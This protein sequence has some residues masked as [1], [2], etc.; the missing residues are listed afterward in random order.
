MKIQTPFSDKVFS[1]RAVYILLPMMI[2]GGAMRFYK[3]DYAGL[4]LDE[5]FSMQE[6]D[7]S[8]LLATVYGLIQKDQPPA[9]FF[10]LHEYLKWTGYSDF[11]GRSLSCILGVF[12]ILAMFFL[13]KE[14]KDERLG[15]FAAF[16]TTINYFHVGISVE[17]RFYPLLFLLSALSYLYFLR[18]I[19]YG[20]DD[21]FVAYAITTGLA[22][23]TH[24][25]GLVLFASQAVIFIIVLIFFKRN[26][27]LV[28]Y[29][30]LAGTA[31]AL[32]VL[33]WLPIMLE[34][35]KIKSFHYP[36]LT[37]P[38]VLKSFWWFVYDPAAFLIYAGLTIKMIHIIYTKIRTRTLA[39]E[40][41]VLLGWLFIGF[42][43][44]LLYSIF[45]LNLFS[46]KYC[47]I[48]L[49]AIF[50]FVSMGFCAIETISARFSRIVILLV[51]SFIVIFFARPHYKK[52]W[53]ERAIELPLMYFTIDQADKKLKRE[54]WRE[55]AEFF[56]SNNKGERVIFAQLASIHA[57]Y[58]KQYNIDPPV[59]HNYTNV[60]D[61]IQNK[62][63]VWLLSHKYYKSRSTEEFVNFL[64]AQ[65]EL[66]NRDFELSDSVAFGM[67]KALL[68]TRKDS[69]QKN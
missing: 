16:L 31:A 7:P 39:L 68:Y 38:Y 46:T 32:S 41:S 1:V 28:I 63:E 15:M 34:D 22:L 6:A 30:L 24:Y 42:L 44:P 52:S 20:R 69:V 4:W 9:Y 18:S 58:F 27:R 33:H 51:S 57:Y 5:I 60:E 43:I 8:V 19:K 11:A 65:Q 64:P 47:T 35:L 26:S 23:N 66:I 62:K 59:D 29:G 55:V 49:P 67:S 45:R 53:N 36:P 14:F 50:L 54:D 3:L 12:G 17:A 10:L 37:L 25:F 48:Q 40:D 21:H 56:A 61:Q 13:G 2:A